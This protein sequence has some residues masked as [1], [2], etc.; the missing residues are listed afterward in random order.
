MPIAN[1]IEEKGQ[2]ANCEP[3]ASL[4]AG[5][6]QI[7]RTDYD[8]LLSFAVLLEP[9]ATYGAEFKGEIEQIYEDI[10]LST[11]DESGALTFFR[12]LEAEHD[13]YDSIQGWFATLGAIAEC[14]ISTLL[15]E[16][17]ES[18]PDM[19]HYREHKIELLPA[20]IYFVTS[21]P[22]DAIAWVDANCC[23]EFVEVKKTFE[24]LSD[25]RIPGKIRQMNDLKV[26]VEA[27]G[28]RR[29]FVGFG[30]LAIIED[31]YVHLLCLIGFPIEERDMA[32]LNV[33]TITAYTIREWLEDR[34][35]A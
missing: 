30:T 21:K 1:F 19:L 33:D 32:W 27:F 13:R 12:A 11:E 24:T 31:P 25:R 16:K 18:V 23:G 34:V 8:R 4:V 15:E 26:K 28:G 22:I 2:A 5:L 17:Y 10:A 6:V 3:L 7:I 14:A 29:S 9:H 20:E 35:A